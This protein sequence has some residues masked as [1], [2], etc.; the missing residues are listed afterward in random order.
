MKRDR[1]FVGLND[2]KKIIDRLCPYLFEVSLHN[3]GEPL[4]NPD[5]F[6]MIRYCKERNVGTNL[7][8]NL[9]IRHFDAESIISAG[10]EYFVVSLDG[11]TQD[12]YG[13]YRVGGNI[14]LVYENMKGLIEKRKRLR[15]KLPFI[16]WQYIVMKHNC[17]Q[18][19]DAKKMAKDMGVDL[20]RFIPVGL[21]FHDEDK[22]AL[23]QQWF[24]Y[25]P[26]VADYREDSFLQKPAK[27]G[28]FY[29]YR[30]V[31][32]NPVGAITPC[33]VLY[34]EADDFGN[35]LES[36]FS[37]VWNNQLYQNA[38]A[39]FSRRN[40]RKITTV[41]HRCTMFVKP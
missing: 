16:E 22:K 2:F 28:C 30:A 25:V 18:I 19:N 4:L 7:S 36:D 32:V 23:A 26:E 17:H 8:T 40:N 13:K 31:T 24:P 33:C 9:N 11:T 10:L 1:R 6:E 35:M 5:I 39:L 29:L 20:I 12:V 21:A 27:G 15:S 37:N 14:D 34:N 41:C 3:W 38:R